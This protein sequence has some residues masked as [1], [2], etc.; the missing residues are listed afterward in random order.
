MER[1]GDDPAHYAEFSPEGYALASTIVV[2]AL[3][4]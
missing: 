3:T 1:E 2:S 4:H